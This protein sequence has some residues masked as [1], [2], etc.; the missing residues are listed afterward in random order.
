MATGDSTILHAGY[1]PADPGM[2]NPGGTELSPDFEGKIPGDSDVL[3]SRIMDDSIAYEYP[4]TD[5]GN[6]EPTGSGAAKG[7]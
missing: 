1:M 4:S 5:Q 2:G 3:S 7:S 6:L